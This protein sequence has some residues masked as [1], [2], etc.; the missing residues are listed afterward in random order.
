MTEAWGIVVAAAIAVIG[1]FVGVFVGRRQ[2]KDQA[3]VEH[4]QWLR[5]QR[6]SAYADFLSAW[7]RALR[8]M[9]EMD[10]NWDGWTIVHHP[11]YPSLETLLG[12]APYP[13]D[14]LEGITDNLAQHLG[15]LL[16]Q[17]QSSLE[18]LQLLGP[19]EIDSKAGEMHQELYALGRK[20]V[21]H[22]GAEDWESWRQVKSAA[23]EKRREFFDLA[24][25]QTQAAPTPTRR[26]LT[27]RRDGRQG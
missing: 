12:T 26:R 13:G 25:R 22:V 14:L 18:R 8:E 10:E 17:V 15:P 5:N 20:L 4:E 24:R 11:D 3:Q 2:V 19:D 16:I 23:Y 9:E 21:E 6:Q 7:D 27:R 1:S